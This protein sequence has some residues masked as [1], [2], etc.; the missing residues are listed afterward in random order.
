MW[1]GGI[2]MMVGEA[3]GVDYPGVFCTKVEMK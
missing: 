3:G 1:M 2:R